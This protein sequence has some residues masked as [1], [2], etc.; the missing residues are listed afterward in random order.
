M[1][2]NNRYSGL[3]K[4]R[5]P[6]VRWRMQANHTRNSA[7]GGCHHSKNYNDGVVSKY[8]SLR[9]MY[10]MDMWC[11]YKFVTRQTK[12]LCFLR[13]L[14]SS[15]ATVCCTFCRVPSLSPSLGPINRRVFSFTRV[16][17]TIL[18]NSITMKLSTTAIL[19]SVGGAAAWS[20]PSRSSLRNLGTKTVVTKGPSRVN[21]N[22][23]KMEGA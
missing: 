15:T 1:I 12:L 8:Y 13:K 2:Q 19:L 11:N 20:Q 17:I 21:G 10:V 3:E 23:M 4:N 18:Y 14:C 22:T 16:L 9:K 5:D 6:S 7:R